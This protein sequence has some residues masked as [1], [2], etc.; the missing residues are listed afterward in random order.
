MVISWRSPAIEGSHTGY[1][2]VLHNKRTSCPGSERPPLPAR[3]PWNSNGVGEARKETESGCFRKVY[4]QGGQGGPRGWDASSTPAEQAPG[5]PPPPAPQEWR[6]R[7]SHA[8]G[9]GST[10]ICEMLV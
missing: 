8:G 4:S 1:Q 6:A 3:E 2:R 5:C 9:A 7:L 10:G